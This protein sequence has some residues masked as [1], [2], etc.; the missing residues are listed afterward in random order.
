MLKKSDFFNVMFFFI[1]FVKLKEQ[2]SCF[3]ILKIDF[4]FFVV[5]LLLFCF[6]LLLFVVALFFS[7]CFLGLGFRV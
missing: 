2:H 7:S 5:V 3:C 6:F 4:P 1:N